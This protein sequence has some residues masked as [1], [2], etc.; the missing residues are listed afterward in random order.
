MK[1][2]L[3]K[4]RVST[5][6]DSDQISRERSATVGT[7]NQEVGRFAAS[8]QTLDRRLKS[9]C[10]IVVVPAE[11]HT[12]IMRAVDRVA[13][14]ERR[15]VGP[16]LM[17][18]VPASG[19]ALVAVIGLWWHFSEPMKEVQPTAPM[20]AAIELVVE[21]LATVPQLAS[22]AMLAPL[23]QE[24]ESLKRDFQGAVRFLAASVP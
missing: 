2:W 21:P 16:C 6:L 18:W 5:T 20:A 15:A 3:A 9:E 19:V 11:L 1:T 14:R 4:F 13:A 23:S 10:P 22:A 12:T 8:L 17:R 7:E 24:M